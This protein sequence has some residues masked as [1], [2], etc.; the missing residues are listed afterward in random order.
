MSV[1]DNIDK[2][3]G[4]MIMEFST[5]WENAIINQKDYLEVQMLINAYILRFWRSINVSQDG[6]FIWKCQVQPCC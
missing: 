3:Y 5:G 6:D 1:K 4:H 2:E